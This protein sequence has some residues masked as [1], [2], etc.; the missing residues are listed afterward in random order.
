[1]V[2][3]ERVAA[4][5]EGLVGQDG[6]CV[7]VGVMRLIR[8]STLTEDSEFTAEWTEGEHEDD[9][10][11]WLAPVRRVTNQDLGGKKDLF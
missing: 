10:G 2:W 5:E 6:V 3:I 7:M 8:F 4:S 11:V 9:S 1:M